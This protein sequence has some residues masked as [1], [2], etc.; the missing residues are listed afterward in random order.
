MK[1]KDLAKVIRSK[2]AGPFY[3]T[4]DVMFSDAE[5]YQKVKATG[6]LNA[7]L[8]ASLYNVATR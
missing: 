4:L 5:T 2:N 7:D 6:T 1:L 3:V 8:I